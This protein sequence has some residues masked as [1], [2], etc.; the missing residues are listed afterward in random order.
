MTWKAEEEGKPFM[1]ALVES[2]VEVSI[3]SKIESFVSASSAVD[4]LIF[5]FNKMKSF[6]YDLSHSS[7]FE[8]FA[9][10][11]DENEETIPKYLIK[12]L[13]DHENET[14]VIEYAIIINSGTI[15]EP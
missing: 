5:D 15:E 9:S 14:F 2:S 10:N 8:C 1:I 6:V 12:A 7:P 11:K 3:E 13:E 4:V